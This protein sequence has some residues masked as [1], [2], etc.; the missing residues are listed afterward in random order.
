MFAAFALLMVAIATEVAAT[1]ALP[2]ADGFRDPVWTVAVVAGYAVS[3]WLLTL[4]VEQIPVSVAY[5]LWAG[6]GTA[7]IAVV[8][9]AFLG[10]RLDWVKASAVGLI[11]VGVALLNL[12]GAH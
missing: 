6:I 10:E 11:V 8:G 4:V 12:R 1:A 5:A 9:V 7:A 2:R 3:I